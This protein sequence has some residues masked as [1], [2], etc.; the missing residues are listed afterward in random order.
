MF[1]LLA[2]YAAL[3]VEPYDPNLMERE[4]RRFAW[5]YVSLRDY[6]SDNIAWRVKPKWHLLLHLSQSSTCPIGATAAMVSLS[7]TS[8][9]P[10]TPCLCWLLENICA[11]DCIL[12]GRVEGRIRLMKACMACMRII[13][14]GKMY[15]NHF[16]EPARA[17]ATVSNLVVYFACHFESCQPSIRDILFGRI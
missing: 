10:E 14:T 1:L 9:R 15:R 4:V 16:L 3:D 7:L 11:S 13:V 2:C 17:S 8:S 12:C 6:Y 5:Q